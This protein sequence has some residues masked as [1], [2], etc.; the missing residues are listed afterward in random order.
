MPSLE[1]NKRNLFTDGL[2]LVFTA[3]YNK[4]LTTNVDTSA[5]EYNWA[6]D[7]HLMNSRGEQ[8]Y[9]HTRSDNNNWNGTVT[10]NYRIGK[11]HMF[12]FNNVLTAFRRSNTSPADERGTDRRHRQGDTQKHC[13]PLL[14]PD[15]VRTLE[16]LRF[17]KALQPVCSRLRWQQITQVQNMS[18]PPAA[19]TPWDTGCRYL[20]CNA[21][22]CRP[23]CR[24]KK[25]T[26]CLPSRKCSETKTLKWAT[27]ASNRK[28]ATT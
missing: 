22:A 9:Q 23:S 5:Y 4:N 2:D 7:K 26:A 18:A 28:T 20:L 6:G 19:S 24:T 3:N 1:Y 13:R 12:T 25:P 15:A 10:L 14:S 8:S 21:A 17:R 27:W 11:A 16:P